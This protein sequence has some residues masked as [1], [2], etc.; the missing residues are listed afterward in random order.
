MDTS[1]LPKK[2]DRASKEYYLKDGHTSHLLK[3]TERRSK[4]GSLF[5]LDG[6]PQRKVIRG[7]SKAIVIM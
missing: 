1:C 2:S 4:E 5:E 6:S 3:Q 7:K